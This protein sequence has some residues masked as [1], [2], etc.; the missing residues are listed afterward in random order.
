MAKVLDNMGKAKRVPIVP[1]ESLR[2]SGDDLM[3]L[4]LHAAQE[5]LSEVFG[6]TVVEAE[7]MIKQRSKERMLWP[8]RFQTDR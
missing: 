8:E 2:I 1:R 6:I 3:D 5:I 4:K 7:E